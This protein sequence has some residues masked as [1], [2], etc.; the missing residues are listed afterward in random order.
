[1]SSA[2]STIEVTGIARDKLHAL[3]A[4]AKAAGVSPEVYAKKLIEEGVELE[5]EARTKSLDEI[6]A[7][8]Q[9]QFRKSGMTEDE[10]DRL[11]DKART[12]HHRRT[13]KKKA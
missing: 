6:F 2:T 1:M 10:L 5:R 9:E 12:Q 13:T 8:A 4:Q 3:R 11:V 7:P